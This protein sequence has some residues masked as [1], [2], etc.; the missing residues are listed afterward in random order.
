VSMFE[1]QLIH[2]LDTETT[3]LP[4]QK[5]SHVI[6]I[7]IATIRVG[8]GIVSTYE[9]ML[10]P[11]SLD[12]EAIKV[13]EQI[14]GIGKEQILSSRPFRDVW[15]EVASY[16]NQNPGPWTAWNVPFDRTMIRKTFLG[17]ND[18]TDIPERL[19]VPPEV[20]SHSKMGWP[21]H[22]DREEDKSP[23]TWCVMHAYSRMRPTRGHTRSWY[24][25]SL[26]P[27]FWS[28]AD[29]AKKEEIAFEG[30]A[31]RALTDARVAAQICERMLLNA[32]KD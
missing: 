3:G 23:W 24:T 27:N 12:S 17:L 29:A 7:G 4:H 13:A 8:E 5:G 11:P 18:Y 32:L 26:E 19:N 21:E 1:G 10:C 16:I 22:F 15:N 14:H 30:N 6:E 9:S 20:L 25:R 28:L 31:H 2:I